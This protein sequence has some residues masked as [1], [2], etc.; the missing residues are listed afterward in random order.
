MCACM[1]VSELELELELLLVVSGYVNGYVP[2]CG[3]VRSRAH[4]FACAC[5]YVCDC[6]TRDVDEKYAF[7]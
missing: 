3:T 1:R 6:V 2:E 4:M 5:V 7:L